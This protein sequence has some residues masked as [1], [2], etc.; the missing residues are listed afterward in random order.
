MM[1]WIVDGKRAWLSKGHPKPEPPKTWKKVRVVHHNHGSRYNSNVLTIYRALDKSLR[2]EIY[3]DG[4]FYAF[5]GKLEFK[6]G[7]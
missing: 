3:R 1:E 5:Y 6:E 4:C 7:K 2:Y